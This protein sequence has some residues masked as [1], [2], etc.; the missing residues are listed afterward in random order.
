[1]KAL[2]AL[3]LLAAFVWGAV[4]GKLWSKPVQAAEP[5]APTN[6][7]DNC[8]QVATVGLLE[9]YQC[10]NEQDGSNFLVNSFGFMYPID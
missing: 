8:E 7:S 3:M 2:I 6:V 10:T 1:M 5:A 9:V 4:A